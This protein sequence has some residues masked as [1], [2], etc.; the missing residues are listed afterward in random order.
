MLRQKLL[1]LDESVIQELERLVQSLS[2]KEYISFSALVR[3]LIKIGMDNMEAET[4]F[5]NKIKTTTSVNNLDN[6]KAKA[7]SAFKEYIERHAKVGQC[8]I[9]FDLLGFKNI[10][11]VSFDK[12]IDLE[13]YCKLLDYTL[14]SISTEGFDV[15]ASIG[16][17]TSPTLTFSVS[18]VL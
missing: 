15:S 18:W 13:Q 10:I 6:E 17:Y 4:S 5:F 8:Q 16:K 2:E 11:Q 1:R 7:L 14:R 3:K 9:S 12:E